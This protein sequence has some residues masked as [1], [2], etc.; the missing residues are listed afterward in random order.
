[1]SNILEYLDWR[2]DI[3]FSVSPFN[4]VDNLILA[5]ICYTDF[6]GVMTQDDTLSIV[7]ASRL[8]FEIHTEEEV[9]GRDTF[10]KMAPIVLKKA[11]ETVRFRDITLKNYINLVSAAR[12]EQYAAVTFVLPEDTIY[13]AFRGTD[14]TIVGWREDFNLSFMSETAGQ[15]RAVEYVNYYFKNDKRPLIFGGHSKGGNFAVYSAV[16]CDTDIQ[17]RIIRVYS[18]DGPGFREEILKTDR[19]KKMLPR[20]TSII[21][22]ESLVGIL[23]ANEYDDKIIKSDAK[24]INQHDPLSWMVYGKSFVETQRRTEVSRVFDNTMM[25][26]LDELSDADR[27]VF[28]EAVF[29]TLDTTGART[30]SDLSEGG[31]R[32]VSEIYKAIKAMPLDKQSELSAMVKRFFKIGSS[33]AILEIK[34]KARRIAKT[35]ENEQQMISAKDLALQEEK[36]N[37]RQDIISKRKA[38]DD[39]ET[40]AKSFE[41]CKQIMSMNIYRNSEVILAYMSAN[42]EVDMSYLMVKA[43]EDG[44]RVYIPKVE[45]E[46]NMRFYLYDGNFVVGSFGIKE[47]L[48]KVPFNEEEM[49]TEGVLMIV[50]G[51]A[52]DIK[53]NRLGHGGGYY[54]RFL[55]RDGK[56][57][58]MAVG[59]DFQILDDIPVFEHDKKMD[60]IVTEKRII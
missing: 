21:P 36:K 37:I 34:D 38:L 32:V 50:P 42:H 16:F 53:R 18:N 11:A 54:D 8:Y 47:P 22:E 41:I 45:S 58:K 5:E 59:Y 33:A 51:V 43:I 44:K 14:N 28:T 60:T 52:F 55:N 25:K 56:V 27:E 17:D 46:G 23:L 49:L 3:P 57:F 20:V 7:D 24:G 4:E 10:Y 12:E 15:R 48:S 29:S 1:M 35:E 19:Y 26:W 13:V 2:G 39:I 30:L 31:I 9:I 40:A 6:E